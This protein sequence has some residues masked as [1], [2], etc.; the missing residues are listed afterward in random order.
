MSSSSLRTLAEVREW[1]FQEGLAVSDWARRRGFRP[2]VVYALLAGRTRGSRGQAHLAAVA[3]GLKRGP[4]ET[5][6]DGETA[7]GRVSPKT[8][9]DNSHFERS[10]SI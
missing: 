3:L 8:C 2:E 4:G 1:F 7:A 5:R 6:K 9:N 10:P